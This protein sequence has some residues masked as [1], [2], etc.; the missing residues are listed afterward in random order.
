MVRE[1]RFDGTEQGSGMHSSKSNSDVKL[2]IGWTVQ[3]QD[4]HDWD[5][6]F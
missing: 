3:Q 6:S 2:G 5:T 1:G 4:Q